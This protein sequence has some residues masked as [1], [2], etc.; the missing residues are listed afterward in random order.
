MRP[1]AAAAAAATGAP[2]A[3]GLPG[4]GRVLEDD[5]ATVVTGA[6]EDEGPTASMIYSQGGTTLGGTG[7]YGGAG[8]EAEGEGTRGRG[9]R[10]GNK[11]EKVCASCWRCTE[12]EH[13]LV[14]CPPNLHPGLMAYMYQGSHR[15]W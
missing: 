9:R 3:A 10:A 15:F 1:S 7:S 2:T 8:D 4:Y 11:R 13:G 6:G 5:T 12:L 14:L